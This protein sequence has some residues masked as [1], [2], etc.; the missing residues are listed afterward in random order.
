MARNFNGTD[1][2]LEGSAI[3]SAYPYSLVAFCY[4]TNV[5]AN[6]SILSVSSS[7]NA[8][9]YQGLRAAGAVANDPL[10]LRRVTSGNASAVAS[11]NNYPANQWFFAGARANSSTDTSV[12]LDQTKGDNTTS[13]SFD[14]VNR[15]SIGRAGYSTPDS[16]LSG[17]VCA[18][19]VYNTG[20]TDDDFYSLSKGISPLK[21][22]PA[23]I[24]EYWPLI[25]RFSPEIG[26]KGKNEL[27]INNLV[28][29]STDHARIYEPIGIFMPELVAAAS[30]FPNFMFD[31][32]LTAEM[33]AMSGGMH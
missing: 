21:V 10:Q 22:K 5:T 12:F 15:L 33:L 18:A 4:V 20:L 8:F 31:A 9:T 24:V 19:A 17:L 30:N 25:G 3:I 13:R 1:M 6:H 7:L 27:T 32:E 11:V 23:N 2:W 29:G 16:Y 14:G 26:V 28:A